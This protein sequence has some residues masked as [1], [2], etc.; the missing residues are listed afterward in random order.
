MTRFGL[1]L[2]ALMPGQP[3]DSQRITWK[4]ADRARASRDTR[5]NDMPAGGSITRMGAVVGQINKAWSR[6]ALGRCTGRCERR[7]VALELRQIDITTFWLSHWYRNRSRSD[8][9]CERF[10]GKESRT[11]WSSRGLRCER[12]GLPS[13]TATRIAD[14]TSERLRLRSGPPCSLRTLM[15]G[16]D[17]GQSRQMRGN[18]QPQMDNSPVADRCYPIREVDFHIVMIKKHPIER[19][20]R[21]VDGFFGDE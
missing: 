18:T 13:R 10:L 9:P 8:C 20:H 6:G 14:A 11:R 4:S 12:L 15:T 5:R 17:E 7:R 19:I 21:L 1:M 2:N 3:R 16:R